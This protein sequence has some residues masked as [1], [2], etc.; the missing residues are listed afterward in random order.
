[1]VNNFYDENNLNEFFMKDFDF[2]PSYELNDV[3]DQK[4]KMLVNKGVMYQNQEGV[5]SFNLTQL[6]KYITF[7]VLIR[8]RHLQGDKFIRGSFKKCSVQQ[9]ID[10]GY[11][12]SK[13]EESIIKERLCPDMEHLGDFYKI[14]NGYTNRTERVSFSLEIHQCDA[15]LPGI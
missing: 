14:K 7:N 13:D 8:H 4:K 12:P 1:M 6:N 9:F 3:D 11:T 15:D 2:L 10:N 5:M